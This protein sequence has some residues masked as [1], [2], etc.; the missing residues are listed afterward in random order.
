ML[1]KEMRKS[2]PQTLDEAFDEN[3]TV[4]SDTWLGISFEAQ[5][6]FY[7]DIEDSEKYKKIRSIIFL[8]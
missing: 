2:G 5:K 3:F 8:I 7:H 1:T 6:I 4:Y